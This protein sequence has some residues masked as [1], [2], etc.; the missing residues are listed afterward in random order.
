MTEQKLRDRISE[1]EE[2]IVQLKNV[3]LPPDNPFIGK[4]NLPPQQLGLLYALYKNEVATFDRLDCVMNQTS[5]VQRSTEGTLVKLRIKVA[6]SKLRQ[7]LVVHG[8]N[9]VNHFGVG[10]SLDAK[11]RACLDEELKMF[12]GAKLG[13]RKND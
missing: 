11:S 12:E 4:I 1:L 3:I 7:N 13:G 5:S 2:E 6:I 10:Y 9:I 8:V